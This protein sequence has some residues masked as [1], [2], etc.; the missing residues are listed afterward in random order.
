[1]PSNTENDKIYQKAIAEFTAAL[2]QL[3]KGD[4]TTAHANFIRIIAENPLE[5]VLIDRCRTYISVCERRQAPEPAAPNSNEDLYKSAVL[6]MNAGD[7][8]KAIPLLDRALQTEPGS[9][10]LLF[11]RSSAWALQARADAAIADLRQ[12][13]AI[14]PTIRF[15]ATNDPDFERIREEPSFIDIIEPTPTGV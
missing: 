10:R 6:M 9:A 14:D 3:Q 13:I 1:M 5:T 2:D 7:A 12:A 4:I 8:D 15:Q 11:A